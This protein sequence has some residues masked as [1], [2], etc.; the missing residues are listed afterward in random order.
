MVARTLARPTESQL[1]VLD[2][3]AASLPRVPSLREIATVYGFCFQYAHVCLVTLRRA[4]LVDWD[5]N[6]GRTLRLT[7]TGRALADER[8]LL[9]AIAGHHAVT[10]DWP[11]ASDLLAD[12]AAERI[13]RAL[14]RMVA[15]GLA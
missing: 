5:I 13:G 8:L 12:P 2:A 10:G 3:I 14:A 15:R 7:A 1:R 11:A 4:G 6:R 9:K